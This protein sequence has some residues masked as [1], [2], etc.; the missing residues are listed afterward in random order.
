MGK[1]HRQ[2]TKLRRDEDEMR[3]RTAAMEEISRASQVD[4]DFADEPFASF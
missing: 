3:Q 1:E 2:I 4:D